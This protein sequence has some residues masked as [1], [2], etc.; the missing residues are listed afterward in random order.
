MLPLPGGPSAAEL[1]ELG[2]ARISY[3]TLVH[4]RAMQWFNEMLW[5]LG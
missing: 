4:R 5:E 1:A 3:G 2:T